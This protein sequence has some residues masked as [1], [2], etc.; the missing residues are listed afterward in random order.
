MQVFSGNFYDWQG[1]RDFYN[2]PLL[3]HASRNE[4]KEV[5]EKRLNFFNKI[6]KKSAYKEPEQLDSS[7]LSSTSK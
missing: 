6:K 4:H 3:I 5:V 7:S 1:C 2:C